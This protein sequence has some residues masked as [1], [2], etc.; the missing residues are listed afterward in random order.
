MADRDFQFA[1]RTIRVEASS[2]DLDWLEEFLAPQFVIGRRVAQPNRYVRLIVD[3]DQYAQV[4]AAGPHPDGTSID[5]FTLDSGFV[6]ARAWNVVDD[7]AVAFDE[8]AGVFY[9]RRHDVPGV[10][11]VLATHVG[12]RVRV[13]VM[14]I[15][16]EFAM[17]YTGRSGSLIVHAAAVGVG[18]DAFVIIGPKRAGK[19]TLLIN[20]LLH[21]RGAFIANDRVALRGEGGAVVAIGIPTIV[22]IR[23]S[24][25]AWFPTLETRL[26][27][28]RYHHQ[29]TIAER[30]ALPAPSER[31][32]DSDWSL[33]PR[34]FCHLLNVGS[35]AVAGVTAL[36][37]P[38]IES[39][40]DG[41]VLEKLTTGEALARVSDSVFRRC[42]T[43][44]MFSING[45]EESGEGM[46]LSPSQ[47]VG[48][49]PSFVCRLGTNAYRNGAG[50][51]GS[52]RSR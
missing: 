43:N 50:W 45:D 28:A 37:F 36:L 31:K 32:P 16:R 7:R 48:Q 51:L 23:L 46:P 8:R 19:T 2:T 11:E 4:A 15:V 17:Q 30:D 3:A 14:R 13:A 38:S 27:H 22:S 9:R 12:R 52:L 44:G 24:S 5:C 10:V 33:S 20:V 29:F 21:E 25:S 1:G 35:R 42:P 18:D 40:A 34:Q 6:T 47:I 41:V 26:A 39:T 49:V